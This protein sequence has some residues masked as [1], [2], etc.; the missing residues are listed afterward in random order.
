MCEAAIDHMRQ[1]PARSLG[2]ATMNQVQRELIVR[3]MDQL[4]AERPEVEEYRQRW[5]NTLERFFVKNLETVQGDERDVIFVSTVFGP[6]APGAKVRQVFGPINGGS[7][8]RRLNVLFTRAKHHVRVFT[9]LTPDDLGV[10]PDGP[11]GAQVLKRYLAYA[12][13]GRLDAGKETG[14]EADSDFEVFVR[15]RLRSAGYDVVPQVGVT[16]FFI[17]LAVRHPEMPGRFLLGIECDGASYHSSKSARDRD[18]LRQK[19]LEY[20]GWTIYRIW[21]TDWF[22]DPTG[23]TRKLVAFVEA[24]RARDRD[25]SFVKS[26]QTYVSLVEVTAGPK[27]APAKGK[28]AAPAIWLSTERRAGGDGP[29]HS[30]G[31]STRRRI[32][33]SSLAKPDLMKPVA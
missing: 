27:L 20:L 3:R 18:I 4:A 22:R 14:R 2:I 19:V 12:Q 1:S 13:D 17:D 9:S 28:E 23:Q 16:G 25:R 10:G 8:H 24:T 26:G 31:R 33:G 21:S 15:D 30:A 32:G 29:S 7:G 11:R 5:V 6:P